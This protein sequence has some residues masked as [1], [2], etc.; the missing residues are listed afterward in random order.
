MGVSGYASPQSVIGVTITF[1]VIAVLA[2][3]L[4]LWTRFFIV[5]HPGLDDLVSYEEH[6]LATMNDNGR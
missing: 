3:A 1:L 5:R 4:R 2:V 6:Q